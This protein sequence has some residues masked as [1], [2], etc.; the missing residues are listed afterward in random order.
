MLTR[1][2][3]IFID[4]GFPRHEYYHE[5]RARRHADVPLPASARTAIRYL[6]PGL[7][8][9]TAHVEFSGIAEAGA[10]PV[11]ICWASCRRRGS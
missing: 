10:E 6:Y 2:A 11:R 5:Q 3:A 8:D 7:Q 1:G 9:I 4:Y